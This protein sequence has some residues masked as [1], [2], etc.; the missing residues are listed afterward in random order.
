MFFEKVS[1]IYMINFKVVIVMVMVI[2]VIKCKL[3]IFFGFFDVI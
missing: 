1:L 2:K 3:S